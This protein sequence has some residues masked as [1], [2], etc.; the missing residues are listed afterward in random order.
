M[1]GQKTVE[2]ERLYRWWQDWPSVMRSTGVRK[3]VIS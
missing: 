1:Q 2:W 3:E